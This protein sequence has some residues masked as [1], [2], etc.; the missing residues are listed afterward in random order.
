[1]S[2]QFYSHGS[3]GLQIHSSVIYQLIPATYGRERGITGTDNHSWVYYI[4]TVKDRASTE[5]LKVTLDIYNS[6]H[7]CQAK[8]H[9]NNKTTSSFLLNF[10]LYF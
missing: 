8:M 2:L 1:M 7:H 5:V 3:N 9:S 4:L 10:G 6:T